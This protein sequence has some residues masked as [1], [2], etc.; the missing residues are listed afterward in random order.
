MSAVIEVLEGIIVSAEGDAGGSLVS[1]KTRP[2]V[3][4]FTAP[5]I[6]Q[7]LLDAV[8]AAAIK[9]FVPDITTEKGREAIK[10]QA[11][12]V[13]KTK[14]YLEQLGKAESVRLK[15]LV[16]PLD[17]GRKELWDGL[18]KIQG[19]TRQPLT[20]WEEEQARLAAEE[21][22]REE[23]AALLRKIEEEH[24][25]AL[26][27]N[28]VHDRKKE[29]IRKAK[30]QEQKDRELR[31]AEEAKKKAK[32]QAQAAIDDAKRREEEAALEALAAAARLEQEKKDSAEREA[33]AREEAAAAERK[34]QADEQKRQADELAKREADVEHR[35]KFNTEALADV[36]TAMLGQKTPE[37]TAKAILTA[38]VTGKV[39]HCSIAY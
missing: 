18:E 39:R 19:E 27:L 7:T 9:D 29:D 11:F 35:R 1:V 34:R 5:G 37:E 28:E 4:I 26:L 31:I 15:A 24:E 38:I 6:V 22:A 8:R 13:T 17:A 10:S 16:A 36:H 20:L 21:K 12:R 23:A 25:F 3:E 14:T 33:R 30:E 2:T 32:A